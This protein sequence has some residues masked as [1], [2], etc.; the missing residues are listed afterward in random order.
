MTDRR[1]SCIAA[2]LS[3]A[4][5]RTPEQERDVLTTSAQPLPPPRPSPLYLSAPDK[6]PVI[7]TPDNNTGHLPPPPPLERS[8]P[9]PQIPIAPAKQ[10]P[11]SPRFPPYEAFKRRPPRLAR[12]SE[13]A[14]V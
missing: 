9:D 2:P 10:R 7:S 13:R 12:P 11:S 6:N 14:G 8:V 5:S 3:L 1:T 4:S